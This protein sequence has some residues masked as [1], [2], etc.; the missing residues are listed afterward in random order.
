MKNQYATV[1]NWQDKNIPHRLWIETHDEGTR[2]C[3][4]IV[5]DVEPEILTLD[6]LATQEQVLEAWHGMASPVTTPYDKNGVYSQIRCL[7]NLSDGCVIWTVNHIQLPNG[8]KISA[9]RL[10]W[11]PSM[12][13]HSCELML[14]KAEVTQ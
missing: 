1:L 3:M 4:K 5:K 2:V 9:D 14:I 13:Q 12:R 11:V 10:A 8:I 7:F 6:L